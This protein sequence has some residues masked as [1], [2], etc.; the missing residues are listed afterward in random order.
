MNLQFLSLNQ[1]RQLVGFL[2]LICQELGLTE[3]QF[4]DAEK[5]YEAV[6][7][8][9]DG[10]ENIKIYGPKIIPQGSISLGT[11]VRPIGR[12]DF[13]I[14]LVCKLIYA[15]PEQDQAYIRNIVGERLRDNKV[16][17]DMLEPL[18]RG[19]RLNYAKSSRF[20]LDITPAVMNGTSQNGEIL[21]PDRGL[22]EWKP[23]NPEGY[24]QWFERHADLRPQMLTHEL[25][26]MRAEVQ[27]LPEPTPFKSI[28]K[29]TVQILKRHRDICFQHKNSKNAPI[30]I[31]ITT[32]AAKSYLNAVRNYRYESEFDILYDV[33]ANMDKYITIN[34]I[35]GRREFF[36]PN[37]T[38]TG[39]N[40]AEKWNTHPERAEAFYR[41]QSIAIE[42]IEHLSRQKG[43]DKTQRALMD[44][45]GEAE[46]TRAFNRYTDS[47]N[48]AR[49]SGT[50]KAS[51]SVGLGLSTGVS[52]QR[53]T[54]FGN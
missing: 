26:T 3:T 37:E 29:R 41:W 13:D 39:E 19:W 44:T 25:Q 43:L 20:H 52:I 4:K 2:E 31:I 38:T 32:L 51:P 11:T 34:Q 28:L 50:L 27:P 35:N 1:K 40:F 49:T 22:R 54:H 42:D 12:D 45:F 46:T 21:V 24:V 15:G 18:N 33:I 6:G 36:I 47:I 9:H 17:A 5:K 14:D 30:S 10:G 8:W 48:N 53:N 16:Y 7:N 23:S